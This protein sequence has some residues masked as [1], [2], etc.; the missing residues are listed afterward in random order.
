MNLPTWLAYGLFWLLCLDVMLN[1]V[2]L[3]TRH[4]HMRAMEDLR[5]LME[6]QFE[7][8]TQVMEHDHA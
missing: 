8:D 2:I 7:P 4:S 1:T 3:I 5:R 6:T